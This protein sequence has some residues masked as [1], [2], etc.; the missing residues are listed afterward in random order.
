MKYVLAAFVLCACAVRAEVPAD[1]ADTFAR[2]AALVDRE[3]LSALEMA[4]GSYDAARLAAVGVPGLAWVEPRFINAASFGEAAVAGAYMTAWGKQAHLDVIRRELETNPLKR[5]WLHALVGTEEQFLAH[6][7]SGGM[8]QPL[9]R[10]MPNVGGARALTLRLI[11]SRDPLVRRAGLFWGF[12]LADANY[13]R[14]VRE[15]AKS[16]RDRTTLRLA[17]EVLRRASS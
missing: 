11:E 13:W 2:L 1:F 17:Q 3:E 5:R 10:L 7:A 15:L 12:W 14:A 16:E 8:Y 6:L 9:I 4:R